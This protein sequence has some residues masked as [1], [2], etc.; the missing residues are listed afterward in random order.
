MSA[1]QNKAI[2]ERYMKITLS[3]NLDELPEVVHKNVKGA[4]GEDAVRGLAAVRA[5]FEGM[6]LGLARV[7][8][9]AQIVAA[10]GEWVAVCGKTTG[11]HSGPVMGLPASGRKISIPG[12]AFFRV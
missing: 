1:R 12:S 11:V 9:A 2:V 3:G 4:D 7:R 8:F 5:Y 6:R 10:E